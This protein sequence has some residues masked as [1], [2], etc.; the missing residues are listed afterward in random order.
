MKTC[1]ACHLDKDESCFSWRIPGVKLQERCKSCWKTY[2]AEWYRN[3]AARHKKNVKQ[4]KIARSDLFRELKFNKICMDCRLPWP[5]YVLQ[6]DHRPG[7]IKLFELSGSARNRG[8]TAILAEM[9]KCDL[10]C[11]NCHAIRTHTRKLAIP[12]GFEPAPPA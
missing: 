9:K 3:N 7:E 6:F 10:I 11:S 1:T 4:V 12:A 2:R 8:M 5:Y